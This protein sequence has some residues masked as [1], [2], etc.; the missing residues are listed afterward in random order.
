MFAKV[1]NEI[2]RSGNKWHEIND[3]KL[4]NNDNWKRAKEY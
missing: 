3:Q 4:T 1:K 2:S